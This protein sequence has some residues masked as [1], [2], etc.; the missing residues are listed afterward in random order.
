MA[1]AG[2]VRSQQPKREA[3]QWYVV[4]FV[5][6]GRGVVELFCHSCMAAAILLAIR[7]LEVWLS[8]LWGTDKVFY[9]RFPASYVFDGADFV[10]LVGFLTGGVYL[11]LKAYFRK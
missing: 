6:L 10:L 1:M 11:I 3:E 8:R 9:A 5:R 7:G 2:D 4:P